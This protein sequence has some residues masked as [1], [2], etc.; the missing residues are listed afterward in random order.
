[1]GLS[2]RGEAYRAR[3]R[4]GDLPVV[5]HPLVVGSLLVGEGSVEDHADVSHGVDADRRALEHRAG[6]RRDRTCQQKT[7]L[8]YVERGS[9]NPGV[10]LKR[11]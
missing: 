1:M 9:E 2:L 4:V 5:G 8:D 7:F 3:S 11:N 6:Q 10:S